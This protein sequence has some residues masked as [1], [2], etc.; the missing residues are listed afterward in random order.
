MKEVENEILKELII[1]NEDFEKYFNKKKWITKEEYQKYLQIK[2]DNYEKNIY[3]T[4]NN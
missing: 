3:N 1:N 2:I 4:T